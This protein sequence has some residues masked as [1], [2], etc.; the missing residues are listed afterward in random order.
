MACISQWTNYDGRRVV[1]VPTLV[2]VDVSNPSIYQ[3]I[4]LSSKF[5]IQPLLLRDVRA[6]MGTSLTYLNKW[7]TSVL[8]KGEN[9]ELDHDQNDYE[10]KLKIE[11]KVEL[12]NGDG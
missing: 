7:E 2:L 9:L 4:P 8:K 1:L 5:Y 11:K 3:A 12:T 6:L 10:L